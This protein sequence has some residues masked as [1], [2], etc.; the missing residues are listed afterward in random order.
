MVIL[1]IIEMARKITK[2][3]MEHVHMATPGYT[4]LSR[5]AMETQCTKVPDLSSYIF[6]CCSIAIH[7]ELQQICLSKLKSY[8]LSLFSPV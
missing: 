4:G 5:M 1:S 7:L 8:R 3:N 2:K 6:R